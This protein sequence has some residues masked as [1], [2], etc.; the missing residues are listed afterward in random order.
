[1]RSALAS[2][3]RLSPSRMTSSRCGGRS[4]LSTAVAAAASGGA[5]IAPSAI[6][7]DHGIPG[8]IQRATAAT[9]AIVSRTAPMAS[10]ATF[11]QFS[12]RSRNDASN[13]ASTSTGATNSVSASSGSRTSVGVP[14]TS[15]SPAPASATSAGYGVPIRRD[16]A[17][18]AAPASK[19]PI[20]ISKTSMPGLVPRP[21]YRTVFGSTSRRL[22]TSGAPRI[23]RR[24]TFARAS[25]AA[26]TMAC[27]AACSSKSG[28]ADGG[29][30]ADSSLDSPLEGCA[31]LAG[32][33]FASVSMLEC[34]PASSCY[35]HVNFEVGGTFY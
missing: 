33:R 21:I 35:W 5:T 15:A 3:K 28:D 1:M 23:L 26:M 31:A 2:L 12:R 17:V 32:N 22:P 16:S 18:S 27:L 14:G 29:P 25:A 34:G 8:T 10:P 7:T 6:A 13:A 11:R 30:H 4:C 20:T 9:T 24:M 19:S